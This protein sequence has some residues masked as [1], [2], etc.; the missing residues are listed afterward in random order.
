M[1]NIYS[2]Y[3]IDSGKTLCENLVKEAD[4]SE[5][6][7]KLNEEFKNSIIEDSDLS[8]YNKWDVVE[9]DFGML[10]PRLRDIAWT[11]EVNSKFGS[12]TLMNKGTAVFD[13]KSDFKYFKQ[14]FDQFIK[15]K[16]LYSSY[17]K[18]WNKL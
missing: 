6:K 14:I 8:R 11:L 4:I 9:N 16:N 5:E 3:L 1:G 10:V 15:V 18:K 17:F 7:L 13:D 12:V 2:K